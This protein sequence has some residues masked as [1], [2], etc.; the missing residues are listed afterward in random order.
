MKYCLWVAVGVMGLCQ[1]NAATVTY[2]LGTLYTGA[3]PS[4]SAPYVTLAFD[5]NNTTNNVTLT[6]GTA[7]LTP[8]TQFISNLWF[9][10]LGNP[11]LTITMVANPNVTAPVVTQKA[12]GGNT[13]NAA[14]GYN[15]VFDVRLEFANSGSGR[16]DAGETAV[17]NITCGACGLTAA[18]FADTASGNSGNIFN[19]VHV[20]G[21]P[22]GL[23]GHLTGGSSSVPEPG[24]YALIGSAL[25]GLGL[26][27]RRK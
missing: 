27:R 7:G 12:N 17:F 5:D 4:G 18:S 11:A 24:T 6:I 25:L 9:N 20:Q 22:Q 23:S 10:V 21:L 14:N 8:G 2:G 16:F 19:A 15:N 13:G 1:A 26:L 3:T